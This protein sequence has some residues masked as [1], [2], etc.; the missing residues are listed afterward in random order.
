RS[1]E[2]APLLPAPTHRQGRRGGQEEGKPHPGSCR[3]AGGH[4]LRSFEFR[5]PSESFPGLAFL[6]LDGA[7]LGAKTRRREAR[8]RDIGL[9]LCAFAS[10]RLR[11]SLENLLSRGGHVS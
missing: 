11:I 9:L 2:G 8:T 3:C 1:D 6:C 10:L 5:F 7:K 4:D